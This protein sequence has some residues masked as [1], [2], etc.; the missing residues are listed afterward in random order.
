MGWGRDRVP[1]I[2]GERYEVKGERPTV[3]SGP[4]AAGSMRFNGKLY[5]HGVSKPH[6]YLTSTRSRHSSA[7]MATAR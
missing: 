6:V 7:R 2:R 1:A 3:D 5:L 4:A